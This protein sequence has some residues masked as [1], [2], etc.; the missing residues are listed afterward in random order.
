MAATVYRYKWASI[1]G[2]ELS[3]FVPGAASLGTSAPGV[4][5]DVTCDST[6][7]S[8]LDDYMASHGWT[9]DST[10]PATTPEVAAS[11][12]SPAKNLASATTTVNVDAATAPTTGQVLTATGG[13]AATWQTPTG[14]GGTPGGATT[15]VQ[16]ND[17][18]AFAG[19]AKFVWD[20]TAGELVQNAATRLLQVSPSLPTGTDIRLA[21]TSWAKPLLTVFDASNDYP[22]Q[23][24][25]GDSS[26]VSVW[27]ATGSTPTV[28]GTSLSTTGTVSHPAI[29][30]TNMLTSARRFRVA[31]A[32]SA[33][34]AASIRGSS[35]LVWRGNAAGLGGFHMMCHWGL[36]TA[37]SGQRCFVGLM[38][39]TT[40]PGA[41][42]DIS[43]LLDMV[44][45]GRDT[46]DANLQFMYNDNSGS[47]TKVDL[48]ASF[49]RSSSDLLETFIYCPPNGSIIY[50]VA[51]NRTSGASA[52][53][54]V[55][56]NLPTA[57]TFLTFHL[58]TENNATA[59]AA[60]L[61]C[62][63]LY[64]ETPY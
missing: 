2:A 59:S 45:F 18:G 26:V 33:G 42:A 23:S 11:T 10:A 5:V 54:S 55:N 7:K 58:W 64:L 57:T 39:Q 56:T 25:L 38:N 30:S 31:S 9:Y 62:L 40:A 44:G 52:S 34:S 6:V 32:A 48:G 53:G 29:A 24:H 28:L 41:A 22:V 16:F 21:N 19:D 47:A 61:D 1:N 15:Q 8:D 17:G 35:T 14:G 4:Y 37:L 12:S 46:A 20:K 51:E 13:T 43:P 3:R 27:P 63:N 50:Y 60:Q 36:S 49:A